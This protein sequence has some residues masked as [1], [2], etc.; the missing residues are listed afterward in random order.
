MFG[1][2]LR[3]RLVYSDATFPVLV[4]EARDM[5]DSGTGSPTVAHLQALDSMIRSLVATVDELQH[6]LLVERVYDDLRPFRSLG[7]KAHDRQVH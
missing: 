5:L 4:S 6:A 3:R 1:W 7:A 2:L